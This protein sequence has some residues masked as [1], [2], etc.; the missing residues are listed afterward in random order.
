[1]LAQLLDFLPTSSA[2]ILSPFEKYNIILGL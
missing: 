2:E 1:V